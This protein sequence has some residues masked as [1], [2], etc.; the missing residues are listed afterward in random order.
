MAKVKLTAA[1]AE[2]F[3]SVV[4][5]LIEAYCEK[6]PDEHD[7]DSESIGLTDDGEIIAANGDDLADVLEWV[8][9]EIIPDLIGK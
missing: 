7:F 2:G 1:E 9:S 8:N 3:A 6:Y 4:N 5:S